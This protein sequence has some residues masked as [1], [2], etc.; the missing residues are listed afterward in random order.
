MAQPICVLYIPEH[1]SFEKNLAEYEK[2]KTNK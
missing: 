1:Y 2:V